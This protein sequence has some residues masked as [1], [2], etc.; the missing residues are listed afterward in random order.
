VPFHYSRPEGLAAADLDKFVA[1]PG[2]R[3][4]AGLS[5]PTVLVDGRIVEEGTLAA[6]REALKVAEADRRWK[7]AIV[8]Q[9]KG[10]GAFAGSLPTLRQIEDNAS[11]GALTTS[12]RIG[13]QVACECGLLSR[14]QLRGLLE[15]QLSLIDC[16]LAG[17]R[18]PLGEWDTLREMGTEYR[19]ALAR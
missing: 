14:E 18:S 19:Q 7:E 4:D 9:M 8:R 10:H 11:V 6:H 15:Q 1:T 13:W 17:Q 16:E 3:C 12:M 2:Y 5:A